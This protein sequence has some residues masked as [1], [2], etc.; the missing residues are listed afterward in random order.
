[1]Y[2]LTSAYGIWA[3]TKVYNEVLYVRQYKVILLIWFANYRRDFFGISD[4][5]MKTILLILPQQQ[6]WHTGCAS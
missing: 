3:L 1:M 5:V 6:C 2:S 4:S